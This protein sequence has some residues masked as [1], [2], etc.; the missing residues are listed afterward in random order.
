MNRQLQ[1][2]ASALLVPNSIALLSASFPRAERGRAIGIW[3]GATAL[4]GASGPVL[5]IRRVPNPPVLRSAPAIDWGGA[6]LSTVGIAGLVSAIIL[7]P[8]D[9]VAKSFLFLVSILA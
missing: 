5:G 6:L 9:L 7:A 4:I 2:L 1:G 3:S 8:V